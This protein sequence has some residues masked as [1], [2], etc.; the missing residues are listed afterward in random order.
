MDW[1]FVP[2]YA[3]VLAFG[4]GAL[5]WLVFPGLPMVAVQ[6]CLG[7]HSTVEAGSNGIAVEPLRGRS[8]LG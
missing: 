4:I 3:L 7:C 8:T 5:W 2:L 1:R 6:E